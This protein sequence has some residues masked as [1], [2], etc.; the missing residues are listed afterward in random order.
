[1]PT[2][3]VEI[4]KS[5]TTKKKSAPMEIV[6]KKEA[7]KAMKKRAMVTDKPFSKSQIISELAESCELSRKQI[8]SVFES[9]N[10]LIGRHL[11]KKAVG[12]FILPGLLKIS[13]KKKPAT[14]ARKGRNP[15]SGEEIMIAAKP[16]SMAV[17]IRPLKNL[18]EMVE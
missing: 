10:D 5:E 2:K 9:L 18:K 12:T 4:K 8:T 11:K 15:F 6:T 13:L 16:A 14:K 3:K 1:M 17:R 7:P